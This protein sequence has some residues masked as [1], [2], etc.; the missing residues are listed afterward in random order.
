VQNCYTI[1]ILAQECILLL[2][3][4]RCS[5]SW[6]SLLPSQVWWNVVC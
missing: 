2:H 5:Q 1:T 4:M 3:E 6:P